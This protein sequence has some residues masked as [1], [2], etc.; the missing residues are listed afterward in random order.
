MCTLARTDNSLT[1]QGGFMKRTVLVVVLV[2]ALTFAFA[3]SAFA[4]TGKFFKLHEL[5]PVEQAGGN[6]VPV[7]PLRP[8]CT[9]SAPTPLTRARTPTT[10]PRPPSAACATPSTVRQAGTKLLP[11]ADA[12]CAGCHTGGT[13]ITAKIITWTPYDALGPGSRSGQPARSAREPRVDGGECLTATA[14]ITTRPL[15]AAPPTVA[16]PTTTARLT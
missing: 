10:W 3:T 15:P 14:A 4:T 7:P 5:L 13:A 16:A 1:S 11:T 6:P 12:T 2:L 9:T 8:V